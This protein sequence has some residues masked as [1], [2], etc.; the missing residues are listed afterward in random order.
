MYYK[1]L[2]FQATWGTP[3]H[4]KILMCIN[5]QKPELAPRL[6]MKNESSKQELY[7]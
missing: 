5:E 2:I 6:V 7:I 1:Y 3:R 4:L